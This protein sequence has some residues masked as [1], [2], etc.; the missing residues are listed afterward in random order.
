MPFHEM[1]TVFGTEMRMHNFTWT[2]G[3]DYSQNVSRLCNCEVE[4][5]LFMLSCQVEGCL[6]AQLFCKLF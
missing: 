2:I 5:Q 4:H 6:L 1:E 3:V